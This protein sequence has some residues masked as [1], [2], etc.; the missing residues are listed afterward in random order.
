MP[1]LTSTPLPSSLTLQLDGNH[2]A[3]AD[4]QASV[5]DGTQGDQDPP[6]AFRWEAVKLNL[7]LRGA[8]GERGP[9]AHPH[10]RRVPRT[11][12]HV[13]RCPVPPP[14]LQ[15]AG[16]VGAQL[17]EVELQ[18]A[19]S[20]GT[21]AIADTGGTVLRP[22]FTF[23]G[24]PQRDKAGPSQTTARTCGR[25]GQAHPQA[26]LA[27][28]R[29]LAQPRRAQRQG[30]RG[31]RGP[32]GGSPAA[33]GPG[34]RAVGCRER[35]R[36]RGHAS[37]RESPREGDPRAPESPSDGDPH[38]RGSSYKGEPR[39]PGTAPHRPAPSPAPTSAPP[40]SPRRGPPRHRP[41][42]REHSP[43]APLTAGPALLQA[44]RRGSARPRPPPPLPVLFSPF[45]FP[46]RSRSWRK[47]AGGARQDG[48]AAAAAAATRRRRRRQQGERRRAPG[49]PWPRAPQPSSAPTAGVGSPPRAGPAAFLRQ[50]VRPRP[51]PDCGGADTSGKA[52]EGLYFRTVTRDQSPSTGLGP[53]DVRTRSSR[54]AAPPAAPE[55]STRGARSLRPTPL[56]SSS[57][58]ACW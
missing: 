44:K 4:G 5:G 29:G 13:A 19:D 32:R 28:Q 23:P 47:P 24:F 6:P 16:P 46:Q 9:T 51:R 42:H 3:A 25:D 49:S 27:G 20:C 53:G 50:H 10:P 12:R 34:Q 58:P 48:R 21:P 1:T 26:G 45:P 56:I 41:A 11:H 30:G 17:Q 31:Q 52:R 33:A 36:A 37:H 15:P 14:H 7:P 2:V 8:G 40:G 43:A 57:S 39:A 18:P 22:G 38:A 54:P 55:R 35:S